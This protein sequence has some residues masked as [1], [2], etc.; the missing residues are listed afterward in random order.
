MMGARI[1]LLAWALAHLLIVIVVAMFNFLMRHII[2]VSNEEEGKKDRQRMR[3][4]KNY[5][6]GGEGSD[7]VKVSVTKE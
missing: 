3:G 4:S 2:G 1:K 7:L 5:H 6:G